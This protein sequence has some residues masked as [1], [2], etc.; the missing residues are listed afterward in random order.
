MNIA[1]VEISLEAS[2]KKTKNKKQETKTIKEQ[3]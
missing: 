3:N 2:Q 1:T